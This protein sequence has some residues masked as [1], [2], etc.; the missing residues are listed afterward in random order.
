VVSSDLLARWQRGDHLDE[1]AQRFLRLTAPHRVSKGNRADRFYTYGPGLNMK[2]ARGVPCYC[3]GEK[4]KGGGFYAT[5]EHG[6]EGIMRLCEKHDALMFSDKERMERLHR[7]NAVTWYIP[8]P[9]YRV[10]S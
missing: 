4:G 3:C 6:P 2:E 7:K 9:L 5:P 10:G 8:N 1:A